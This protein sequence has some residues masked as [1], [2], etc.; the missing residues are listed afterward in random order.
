MTRFQ[1]IEYLK[2]LP[3][4]EPVFVL[5][6][7]DILADQIVVE[8]ANLLERHDG[9]SGKIAGAREVA[10]EMREWPYRKLPD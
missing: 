4:S 8:W 5:R 3:E 9:R 2:Q 7:T 10:K 6:A 1:A